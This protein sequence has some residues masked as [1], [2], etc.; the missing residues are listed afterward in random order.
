MS[1]VLAVRSTRTA[2]CQRLPHPGAGPYVQRVMHVT[3]ADKSLLIGDDTADLLVRYAALLGK[4]G[5]ADSVSLR[6][7]SGDGD[8]VVAQLLL[9]SGTVLMA[10]TNHSALPEPNNRDVDE[11]LKER[12]AAYSLSDEMDELEAPGSL[13]ED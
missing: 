7:I 11:Y 5:S 1:P 10:E 3:M 8:E 12:L 4:T 2:A 9:N 13:G 6:A